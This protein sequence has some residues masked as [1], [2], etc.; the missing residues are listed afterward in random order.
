VKKQKIVGR[1]P[2]HK[3]SAEVSRCAGIAPD[4][5]N[6]IVRIAAMAGMGIEPIG[7]RL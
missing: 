2:L 4:T 7:A 1:R 5:I 3:D 6:Q